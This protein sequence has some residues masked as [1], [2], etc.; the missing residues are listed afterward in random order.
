MARERFDAAQPL[1]LQA[2][3]VSQRILGADHPT[4]LATLSSLGRLYLRQGR[5]AEAEPLYL[6]AFEA[7]R[8]VLG[9]E[10]PNT[11]KS[12]GNL[13]GY[14]DV[15]GRPAE[16]E[17]LYLRAFEASRRVLG[18]AHAFSMDMT[19]KL[20]ELY[21]RQGRPADE[22]RLLTGA[23]AIQRGTLPPGPPVSGL[24][25]Q[26]SST[27]A[28]LLARL[29]RALLRQEKYAEAEPLIRECLLMREKVFNDWRLFETQSMLGGSLAGQGAFDEAEPLL[30]S[31][32]E[33]MKSRE[34]Q[35]PEL[36]KP[37]LAEAAERLARFYDAT[38]DPDQAARWREVCAQ[39]RARAEA[40]KVP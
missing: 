35:R 28:N 6:Q 34:N 27:L 10:H 4:T 36:G 24:D 5:P 7:S 31:G 26:A 9:D 19:L 14:Y 17:P 18:P 3:K 23:L 13:A 2:R 40:A 29:G 16:A 25:H 33:G 32:Y 39:E 8:R 11:L 1:L 37:R 38:D 22:E 15:Q 12:L 30:L 21:L 20:A